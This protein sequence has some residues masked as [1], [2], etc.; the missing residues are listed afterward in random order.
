[1]AIKLSVIIPNKN[2]AK[3]L[4]RCLGA[5]FETLPDSSEV[6]IVDDASTD[7]S[8]EIAKKFPCKIISLPNPS[9]AAVARNTGAYLAKGK[10][11]FFIDSDCIVEEDTFTVGVKALERVGRGWIIGGTYRPKAEDHSFF[12]NFQAQFINFFELKEPDA[13][14][15]IATH[16]MI[17]YREDFMKIGGFWSNELPILEDVEFSHR[18]KRKGFR[19]KMVDGLY[20]RHIFN[21]NILR[22]LKNAFKK[23]LYW[24]IYS[25]KN[26]DLFSDSGTAS[27]ELKMTSV[28]YIFFVLLLAASF[29][30]PGYLIGVVITLGGAIVI[31]RGLYK[32]FYKNH[33]LLYTIGAVLYMSFVYPA[34]V[35]MG[36]MLGTVW[37]LKGSVFKSSIGVSPDTRAKVSDQKG[38]S[39]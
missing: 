14:D 38:L 3:T 4:K 37:Y 8:I 31:N 7:D 15:Y 18:A 29:L 2:S 33:G 27:I 21:F 17:M 30:W 28:F 10:I 34:S 39:Q 12:S 36:A 16:L 35:L 13:P 5:V 32:K 19:L 23:S 6:I 11:L 9:G 24:C 1:M 26:S 20:V 25:L 22:S